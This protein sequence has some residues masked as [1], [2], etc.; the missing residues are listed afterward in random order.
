MI[1]TGRVKPKS[2]IDDPS[3]HLA[4]LAP[5]PPDSPPTPLSS[6]L[7]LP[8][9]S[10][11]TKSNARSKGKQKGSTM[12]RPSDVSIYLRWA[13]SPNAALTLLLAPIILAIPT[14]YLLPCL[15]LPPT[16]TLDLQ[17]L[18]LPG[19]TWTA[20]PTNPFTPFFLLSHP[21]PPPPPSA[22]FSS[23]ITTPDTTQL[24]IKGPLDIPLLLWTIVLCSYLRLVFTQEVF[25]RVARWWGIKRE[26][27]VARFGEQGYAVVYFAVVGVWGVQTLLTT[28]TAWFHTPAFWIGYPHTHLSGAM[29]RYYVLQIGYWV[30][31]WAVLLLGL[32]KRRSDYWE[33]MVHHLV[34]V[35]MVSWSYL[36][37]VTLLGTAVFVSM[38]V[39]DLL[40]AISKMFNYLQLER[41]KV[42]S[43]TVFVVAWT[44]F[45]HYISLRIL[46]SLRYEF[47]D[48][49]P[50]EH[51]IFSP[52]TGI[53][54][55]LWMRDQMFYALCVL[56][57]LNLFWYYLILRILFRTIF[58]AET[59]DNRSDAEEEDEPVAID[60]KS[61][62]PSE[63]GLGASLGRNECDDNDTEKQSPCPPAKSGRGKKRGGAAARVGNGNGNGSV[64]LSVGPNV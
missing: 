33:Y 17:F 24:Y 58:H 10:T 26:G 7:S 63:K 3:H 13:V 31:Q 35:W 14:H 40:L 28:P 27:K 22:P 12:L 37:N 36:M 39:P 44:Y 57:V 16:W 49:V 9:P 34:T 54:M 43:F 55:A 45:R 53:Y 51:Q 56:Q 30:Q 52:R 11:P 15:P 4:A 1:S 6:T 50:K 18:G 47:E 32:E 42:V 59:D 38:D 29:K 8:L 19:W 23:A 61:E 62:M 2:G 60:E 21:A 20:L 48:L 5:F 41:P 25:P 46:W 64:G